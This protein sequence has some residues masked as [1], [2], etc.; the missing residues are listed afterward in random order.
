MAHELPVAARNENVRWSR[1]GRGMGVPAALAAFTGATMLAGQVA[2]MRFA[3]TEVGSGLAAG[4]ISLSAAMVGLAL[5]AAVGGRLVQRIRPAVAAAVQ[6]ALAGVALIVSPYAIAAVGQMAADWCLAQPDPLATAGWA[7][8]LAVGA[9]LALLN[10]PFGML[11]PA[12]VAMDQ[13]RSEAA[14]SRRGGIY[15]ALQGAGAVAGAITFALAM[16]AHMGYAATLA[17]LS[18]G[19]VAGLVL[20]LLALRAGKPTSDTISPEAPPESSTRPGGRGVMGLALWLGM[21]GLAGELVWT[22]SLTFFLNSQVYVYGM[23]TAVFLASLCIGGLLGAWLAPQQRRPGQLLG[24]V[25]LLVALL[26]GASAQWI[27]GLDSFLLG[28]SPDYAAAAGSE[29]LNRSG[30]GEFVE[31]LL[32]MGLA[33]LVVVGPPTILM[34]V[35]F[36]LLLRLGT[37]GGRSE[38]AGP[39]AGRAGWSGRL[40]GRVSAFNALGSAIGPLLALG[41]L[42]QYLDT[43]RSLLALAIGYMLAALWAEAVD[44]VTGWHRSKARAARP[45]RGDDSNHGRTRGQRLQQASRLRIPWIN[46]LLFLAAL[47]VCI[48]QI[49]QDDSIY[50][51]SY[52][53]H[54]ETGKPWDED[55]ATNTVVLDVIESPEATVAVRRNT[56]DGVSELLI[57]QKV[58]GD[59]SPT[60]VAVQRRQGLLPLVLAPQTPRRAVVVGLGTGTTIAPLTQASVAHIRVAELVGPVINIANERFSGSNE[61]LQEYIIQEFAPLPD[62]PATTQP[63]SA[64]AGAVPQVRV[65]H[66]DGRSLLRL[67]AEPQDLILVD[68]VYP[69]SAGAGGLFSREFYRLAH[70][71]LADGGLL[72]HWLPL[73]QIAPADTSA[74]VA[75]FLEGFDG[76][77]DTRAA[78]MS[79]AMPGRPMLALVGCRGKLDLSSATLSAAIARTTSA[80]QSGRYDVTPLAVNLGSPAQVWSDLLTEP[81]LKRLA[82]DA[83]AASD[84]FPVT[85]LRS[86][87][88]PADSFADDNLEQVLASGLYS[89]GRANRLAE[90]LGLSDA[91]RDK[92][93]AVLAGRGKMVE[94]MKL[95][96]S[97]GRQAELP[98]ILDLLDEALTHDPDNRLA[99]L[100]LGGLE[101]QRGLLEALNLEM[102]TQRLHASGLH[103]EVPR[104][105]RKALDLLDALQAAYPHAVDALEIKARVLS[106]LRRPKDAVDALSQMIIEAPQ[107]ADA[108]YRQAELQA[109]LG[110]W[111]AA[112]RSL[113]QA[114]NLRHPEHIPDAYKRLQT[115]IAK[116]LS[117]TTQPEQ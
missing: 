34:G 6:Q 114:R 8:P 24:G 19:H 83:P 12:V 116:H 52:L 35:C 40:V 50:R 91:D 37:E 109:D 71:R 1:L 64:P 108:C 5:G 26:M 21:L 88:A 72:V 80:T 45:N 78:V 11:L 110:Q 46:I 97:P 99:A 107:S 89:P 95:A 82:G 66:T 92:L 13:S 14:V 3:Q 101:Y 76:P 23:T 38:P 15:Y 36:P 100:F 69:T 74:I 103:G 94:A 104:V 96:N 17:W 48:W 60:G 10:L 28:S 93:S 65:L 90:S 68:I 30:G 53:L 113:N 16:P 70:A 63:G 31:Q 27:T 115:R 102:H 54:P 62:A 25:V 111:Q 49:E 57:D 84:T 75:G 20:A 58:Q 59:D 2:W 39:A 32:V 67:T 47:G 4:A 105:G 86:P 18:S 117:A 51:E 43:R 98:R 87:L 77:G 41:F 61:K 9:M 85:E 42:L 112:D 44:P 55:A 22:R 33:T 73:W 106:K 7:M 81:M 56:F 29:V 79:L